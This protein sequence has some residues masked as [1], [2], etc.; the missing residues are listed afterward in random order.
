MAILYGTQSNGETLPVQVNEFGQLVAQPLPGT[1]GPPGP[2]GPEGPAGPEGPPGKDAEIEWN[3]W[4]WTPEYGFSNEGS[5]FFEYQ[6]QLG[7]VQY[8]GGW[9][10]VRG[11]IS[12]S[13]VALTNLKGVPLLKKL[14]LLK[15]DAFQQLVGGRINL[16]FASGWDGVQPTGIKVGVGG[17][18][19]RMVKSDGDY[20]YTELEAVDFRENPYEDGNLLS[21]EYSG[22]YQGNFGLEWLNDY[23][24]KFNEE[25]GS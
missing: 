22:I 15:T 12:T 21:F 18:T 4:N 7:K 5:A 13:N 23:M 16:V 17:S 10:A 20:G 6:T 1:Q 3:E 14:P 11:Y 2:E 19:A 9:V 25:T 24:E 8:L